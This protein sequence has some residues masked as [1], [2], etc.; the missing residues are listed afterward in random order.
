MAPGYKDKDTGGVVLAFNG[1]LVSWTHTVVAYSMH[2]PFVL[3]IGIG[4]LHADLMRVQLL[5]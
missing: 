2:P 3:R 1:S 4:D 5:S